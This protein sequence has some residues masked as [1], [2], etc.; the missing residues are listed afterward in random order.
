LGAIVAARFG[1][2][3]GAIKGCRS[4][5]STDGTPL[6]ELVGAD[7]GGRTV[8]YLPD[9]DDP[10]KGDVVRE[11]PKAARALTLPHNGGPAIGRL[12]KGHD[13]AKN[14]GFCRFSGEQALP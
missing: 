12:P 13:L 9:A 1:L 2:A 4:Y 6:P 5:T 11:A 14:L 10:P 7:L 3:I 8:P